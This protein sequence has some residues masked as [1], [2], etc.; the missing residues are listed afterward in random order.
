M[1]WVILFVALRL[2]VEVVDIQ[3]TPLGGVARIAGNMKDPKKELLIAAAGP[4]V[5]LILAALG[6][7]G[8]YWIG[9]GQDLRVS[10]L[11][12]LDGG[13]E[14]LDRSPLEIFTSFNIVLGT[15]NLFPAF[16][17]DGGRI[18]RAALSFRIGRLA[19]T[20]VACRLGFWTGIVLILAPFFLLEAHWWILLFIGIFLIIGGVKERFFIET[21][22][23][24][25]GQKFMF[26][27]FRQG[28]GFPPAGGGFPP[29]ADD[30][31]SPDEPPLESDG[32]IIDVEGQS[33]IV[34]DSEGP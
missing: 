11:L 27:A 21:R 2:G 10:E 23:G 14:L 18:L 19:A 32:R 12:L 26:H 5:N 24:G 33:R 17:V 16:P 4:L 13:R 22:E 31:D 34:D 1:S 15:L 30:S 7:L 6:L 29:D 3:L 28:R 8:M 25:I 20:R 9:S